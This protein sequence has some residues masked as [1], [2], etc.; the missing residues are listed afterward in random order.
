MHEV[1]VTKYWT[2]LEAKLNYNI[3][4]SLFFTPVTAKYWDSLFPSTWSQHET[5]DKPIINICFQNAK[6]N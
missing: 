3:P 4:D 5:D 1:S 6:I 2:Q